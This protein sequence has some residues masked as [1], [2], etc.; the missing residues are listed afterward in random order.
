MARRIQ[1]SGF[2]TAFTSRLR[3]NHDAYELDT[4]YPLL[5]PTSLTPE[6][7][8]RPYDSFLLKTYRKN[9]SENRSWP[10]PPGGG[11]VLPSNWYGRINDVVRVLF[12]VKYLDGVQFL[13]DR[14]AAVCGDQGYGCRRH[15]EAREEGYYAAHVS[16]DHEISVPMETWDTENIRTSLEIQI[17]TQL[18]ENI[19][20]M[21]HTYYQERRAGPSSQ[22]VDWQWDY[23]S[24]AFLANYL[25]HVLRVV[26]GMVMDVRERQGKVNL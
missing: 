12:V 3:D 18:Q 4:G 10:N 2:W 13:A 24:D 9:V 1:A 22:K 14:I 8:I 17:T 6:L 21:L 7:V 19:R 5:L 23:K 25:G 16:V 15:L 11:W 20:Q 26:E